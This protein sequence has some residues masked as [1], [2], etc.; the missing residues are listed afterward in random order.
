MNN[1]PVRDKQPLSNATDKRLLRTLIVAVYYLSASLLVIAGVIKFFH[2]SV[3]DI[4]QFF[5]DHDILSFDNV[6]TIARLQPWVECFIG[7]VA[8]T[9]WRMESVAKGLAALYLF[10]ALL[11][12]I[13]S[14]GHLTLPLDC[15]CFGA[16]E[17]AAAWLLLLRN[18][19]LALPLFLVRTEDRRL[20]LIQWLTRRNNPA[21]T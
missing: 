4:L 5:L 13:A 8:L 11:I 18:L 15:G 1:E 10:F 14:Q 12:L 9:G 2:P 17:G 6:I 16:S 3:G 7:M 20:S 21:T 19:A